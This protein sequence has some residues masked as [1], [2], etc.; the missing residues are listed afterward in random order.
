MPSANPTPH[1]LDAA[2]RDELARTIAEALGRM[3]RVLRDSFDADRDWT[4]ELDAQVQAAH[5][6]LAALLAS[7]ERGEAET[8]K[9]RRELKRVALSRAA[10]AR[11]HPPT[12]EPADA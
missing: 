6:A 5:D 3:E 8:K 12:K 4:P 9:L 10:A 1:P 7:V 11:A 2:A